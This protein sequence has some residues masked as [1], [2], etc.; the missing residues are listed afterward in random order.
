MIK[1]QISETHFARVFYVVDKN[2]KLVGY[3][4]TKDIIFENKKKSIKNF[5]KIASTVTPF[6]DKEKAAQLFAK[7]DMSSLPVVNKYNQVVGMI[8]ADY[9]IDVIQEE[10]NEDFQVMAGIQASETPYS[11][12]SSFKLF[13]SRVM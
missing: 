6:T 2:N 3:V 9:V 8:T 13:K 7:H 10:A 5:I 1:D 12:T 11:K 4:K